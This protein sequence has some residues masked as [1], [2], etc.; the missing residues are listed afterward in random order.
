M[1]TV[2]KLAGIALALAVGFFASD[3]ARWFDTGDSR[4]S[5]DQYCVLSSQP[6]SQSNVTMTLNQ[7]TA[8]PLVPVQIS[9][10]W[11]QAQSETLRLDLE[12]LEMEMGQARFVLKAVGNQRYEG[13][14]LLPVCT[15]NE[16][17]WLGELSDGHQTV[18]PAI[19]MKR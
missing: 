9:V 18:Y 7:N 19:R 5:L 17:T 16:M 15:Q 2:I 11:P 13:E 1:H 10:Q 14:V 4:L 8:Q 6:C 12:G 3:I